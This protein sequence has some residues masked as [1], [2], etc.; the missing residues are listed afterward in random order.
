MI[1]KTADFELFDFLRIQKGYKI[2][3]KII[4]LVDSAK[5][6]ITKSIIK[7]FNID[8]RR[9]NCILSFLMSKRR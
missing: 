3:L 2:T 1:K 8:T 5:K 7:K 6:T 4:L 9:E